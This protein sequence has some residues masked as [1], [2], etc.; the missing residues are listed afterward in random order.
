MKRKLRIRKDESHTWLIVSVLVIVFFIYQWQLIYMIVTDSCKLFN[1][2]WL[3]YGHGIYSPLGL[4][5]LSFFLIAGL[6]AIELMRAICNLVSDKYFSVLV[7]SA[8]IV[9]ALS[10]MAIQFRQ[11][12]YMQVQWDKKRYAE[13]FSPAPFGSYRQYME[14]LDFQADQ[15]CDAQGQITGSYDDR[16]EAFYESDR[17]RKA[18]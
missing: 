14:F 6:S 12:E 18:R 4:T 8:I 10:C 9:C 16:R 13:A 11:L 3:N 15:F 17:M 7:N 5:F 2:Y 1:S